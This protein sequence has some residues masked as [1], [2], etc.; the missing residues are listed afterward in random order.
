VDGPAPYQSFAARR[1]GRFAGYVTILVFRSEPSGYIVD[2]VTDRDDQECAG[3]LLRCAFH[4]MLDQGATT[5]FTWTLHSGSNGAGTRYLRKACPFAAHPPL[6]VAARVL[7]ENVNFPA[8]GW[9]LNL[10]DF[11]GI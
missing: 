8:Q 9:Q 6:H 1:E 11:D 2:L 3:D 7:E 4:A 5:L 10:G